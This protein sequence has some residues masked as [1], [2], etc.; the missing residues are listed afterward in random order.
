ME[1]L[2]SS[3]YRVDREPAQALLFLSGAFLAGK[4]RVLQV[5]TSMTPQGM[6]GAAATSSMGLALHYVCSQTTPGDQGLESAVSK[7]AL[8]SMINVLGTEF[9]TKKICGEVALATTSLL[10]FSGM[11]TAVILGTYLLQNSF[12]LPSREINFET[13]EEDIACLE[14]VPLDQW[15]FTDKVKAFNPDEI[16]AKVHF[17][18]VRGR[19]HEIFNG[20]N[21]PE[22]DLIECKKNVQKAYAKNCSQGKA[23]AWYLDK[24]FS[25]LL[26]KK[27]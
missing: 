20:T 27:K 17:H 18:D 3:F 10:G 16:L 4:A 24:I 9:L 25:S 19:Y 13:V 2:K 8:V 12:P 7:S 6:M 22:E 21:I 26:I 23:I 1:Q 11:T 5:L 15:K 14:R